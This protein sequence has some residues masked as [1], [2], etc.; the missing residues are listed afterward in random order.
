MRKGFTLIEILVV[1]AIIGSLLAF[2]ISQISGAVKK[3]QD[4]K[5]ASQLAALKIKAEQYYD[6]HDTFGGFCDVVYS[7]Q[8]YTSLPTPAFCSDVGTGPGT[9]EGTEADSYAISAL[10]ATDPNKCWCVDSSGNNGLVD[11]RFGAG[12]GHVCEKTDSGPYKCNVPDD[13]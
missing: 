6:K 5:I 11:I 13:K 4:A 7:S 9:A 3:G 12:A 10:L 2:V 1:T 8:E